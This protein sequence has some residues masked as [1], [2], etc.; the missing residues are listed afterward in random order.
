MSVQTARLSL[1]YFV[2]AKPTTI[3]KDGTAWLTK[4]VATGNDVLDLIG[5]PGSLEFSIEERTFQSK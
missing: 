3:K 1:L 5:P 2:G 4:G